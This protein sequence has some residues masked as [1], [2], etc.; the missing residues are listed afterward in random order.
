MA[1]S[2]AAELVGQVAQHDR[3]TATVQAELD[4]AWGRMDVARAARLAKRIGERKAD[5]ASMATELERSKATAAAQTT[6]A[7]HTMVRGNSRKME[8]AQEFYRLSSL[9][10]TDLN[11]YNRRF[12]P[13]TR[14]QAKELGIQL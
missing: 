3:D 2:R 11:K 5:R 12:L 8:L 1:A 9:L 7:W 6:K 13:F 10:D 14:E 4:A